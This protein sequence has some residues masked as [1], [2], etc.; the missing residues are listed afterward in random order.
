MLTS[1][2]EVE[3]A[4]RTGAVAAAFVLQADAVFKRR[5]QYRIAWS[6]G[7]GKAVRQKCQPD[8]SGVGKKSLI[9]SLIV[10]GQGRTVILV[11]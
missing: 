5:I 3:V 1:F 6:G 2:Y 8:G 7:D 4:C 10:P 9:H 11:R